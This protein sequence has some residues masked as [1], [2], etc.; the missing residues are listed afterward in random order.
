MS[1]VRQYLASQRDGNRACIAQGRG[2]E[3][4]HNVLG[5]RE[6]SLDPPQQVDDHIR[7][8]AELTIGEMLDED[9]TKERVIGGVN[10]GNEGRTQTRAEVTERHSPGCRRSASRDQQ[11]AVAL[12]AKVVEVEQGTLRGPICIVDCDLPWIL[13][14]KTR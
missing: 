1:G 2:V 14:E 5:G 10:L 6:G 13:V 8:D 11:A 7:C 12:D 9:G 3:A 4:G